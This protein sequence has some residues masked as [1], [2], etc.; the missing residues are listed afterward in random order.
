[1]VALD[2]DISMCTLDIVIGSLDEPV[3]QDCP[4]GI[5]SK[6]HDEGQS[7]ERVTGIEE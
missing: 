5:L 7:F 1:M 2:V 4:G 3:G 6:T